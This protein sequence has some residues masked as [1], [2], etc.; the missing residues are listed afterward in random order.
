MNSFST[1][2]F[3][4]VLPA[5]AVLSLLSLASPQARATIDLGQAGNYAVFGLGSTMAIGTTGD[6]LGNTFSVYGDVAIGAD[7]TS[8]TAAGFGDFQKGFIQGNLFADKNTLTSPG[9]ATWHINKDAGVTGNID[10]VA[11]PCTNTAGCGSD[12]FGTGNTNLSQAVSDAVTRSAFYGALPGTSLGVFSPG[13]TTLAAGVYSATDVHLGN[14]VQ[15]TI[16]GAAGSTFV[17]NDSGDFDFSGAIIL[18]TGGIT[19]GDVLF[20]VT[21]TGPGVTVAKSNAVFQGTLLAVSRDITLLDIGVKTDPGIGAGPD[22]I[23]GTD[24]DNTGFLGR[25]IGALSCPAPC[26]TPGIS[27]TADGLQ[28]ID[29]S[30]AEVNFSGTVPAPP[31]PGAVPEPSTLALFG[32]AMLGMAGMRRTHLRFRGRAPH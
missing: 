10:G 14:G 1:H 21:G 24:D 2:R 16:N 32:L 23:W 31:P 13:N 26:T 17:L 4:T 30:G 12:F 25:V 29:H 9:F 22:G 28:L 20:N 5:L 19:P 6:P 8:A 7:T 3:A 27:Q 11:S 15:L 18:L